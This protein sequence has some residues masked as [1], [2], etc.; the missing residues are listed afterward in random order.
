MNKPTEANIE[1]YIDSAAYELGPE[2]SD[3]WV[4]DINKLLRTLPDALA[5]K[6]AALKG[7]VGAMGVFVDA[8][9]PYPD[10][11]GNPNCKI[12]PAKKAIWKALA[13]CRDIVLF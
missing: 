7:A 10:A 5:R 11:C 6:D 13:A 2:C 12:C 9:G 4:Q 8:E 3:T 1:K